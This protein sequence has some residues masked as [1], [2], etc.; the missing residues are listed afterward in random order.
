MSGQSS[1]GW[2][3]FDLTCDCYV[4]LT[5]LSFVL[6]KLLNVTRELCTEKLTAYEINEYEQQWSTLI[7]QQISRTQIQCN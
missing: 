2:Y 7:I 1:Y 6:I 5:T 3:N 4:T